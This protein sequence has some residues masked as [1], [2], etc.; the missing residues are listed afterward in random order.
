VRRLHRKQQMLAREMSKPAIE[1]QEH[2]RQYRYDAS[3]RRDN[4]KQ[5]VSA[6]S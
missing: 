3:S 1:A 2:C 5:P 4:E 6:L